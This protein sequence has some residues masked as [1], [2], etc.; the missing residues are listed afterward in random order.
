M[1]NVL[2]IGDLHHGHKNIPRFRE[3]YQSEQDQYEDLFKKWHSVVTKRDV[4]YVMGD[5]C[6]TSERLK[7]FSQ[8]VGKKILIMGNHD[9]DKLSMQEL[10]DAFNG[11]IYSLKKYKEFWLSHAPIHPEE[12]RGKHNI[13]GHTHKHCM[14][15]EADKYINVCVEQLE[16]I[17]ISLCEIRKRIL[18][19][20]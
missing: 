10:V 12:L 9:R 14:E 3:C 11:E 8:W 18:E 16:G 1:A 6:F 13:H 4:V 2:F 5:C 19:R 15:Y 20:E 17:P 7:E